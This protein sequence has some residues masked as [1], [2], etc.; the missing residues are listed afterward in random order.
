MI[1]AFVPG[2][3]VDVTHQHMLIV[4]VVWVILAIH[5]QQHLPS[6]EGLLPLVSKMDLP[7]SLEVVLQAHIVRQ[8]RVLMEFAAVLLSQLLKVAGEP[9]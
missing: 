2:A 7:V 6:Q 4:P 8:A 1:Q 9:V 5:A 3:V